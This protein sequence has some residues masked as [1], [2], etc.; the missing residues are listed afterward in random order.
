MSTPLKREFKQCAKRLADLLKEEFGNDVSHSRALQLMAKVYGYRNW[1]TVSSLLND[2]KSQPGSVGEVA[3]YL[4]NYDRNEPVMF[5]EN[6][7]GTAP[8]Y[9]L[10]AN[11]E[12]GKIPYHEDRPI[13]AIANNAEVVSNIHNG[14]FMHYSFET[15]QGDGR[16][17]TFQDDSCGMLPIAMKRGRE[18]LMENPGIKRINIHQNVR[19]QRIL[20]HYL[21]RDGEN[22]LG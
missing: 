21:L 19:G 13:L 14:V 2:E 5:A 10:S 3:A 20:A 1:N 17:E 11:L 6:Y 18:L 12:C 16:S 8:G 7:H 4:F 15:I 9:Y 22:I